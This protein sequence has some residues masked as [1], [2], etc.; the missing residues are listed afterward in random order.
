VPKEVKCNETSRNWVFTLNNYTDEDI[1]RLANPYEQVKYI[2]YGKEIAPTTNTP[3]LKGYMCLLE[4]QQMSFFKRQLPRSHVQLMQGRL[5]D[6]DA[7]VEKEGDLTTWGQKP[8]QGLCT[9][10]VGQLRPVTSE[11]RS[12]CSSIHLTDTPESVILSPIR[13]P[14]EFSMSKGP[15]PVLRMFKDTLIKLLCPILVP[16][17]I[18]ITTDLVSMV[19]VSVLTRWLN[20]TK[21]ALF[22]MGFLPTLLRLKVFLEVR[23]SLKFMFLLVK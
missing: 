10:I 21:D 4:P 19:L 13:L 14:T 9:D 17:A 7:Y 15:M 20:A 1:K 8:D 16:S 22:F 11:Y 5:Q 6:N 2:A 12:L 23:F 3:H 18:S